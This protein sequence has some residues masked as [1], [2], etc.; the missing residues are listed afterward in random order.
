MKRSYQKWLMK[1]TA[2]FAVVCL[3]AF[4]LQIYYG[5]SF[6]YS[7]K[8]LSGDGLVQ[9][10]NALVYYGEYLRGILKNIF[11]DHT[12]S[13]P[14]Y[15][16]SIGLG[17]DILTT[18]NYYVMGD[19]LNLLAVLVPGRY[20]ELLYNGLVIVRLYLAGIA[21]YLYCLYHNYDSDKVLPGVLIYVFSFYTIVISVV[22]P[23]FLNPLIYF[24]LILLGIDRVM[25]E[26]KPLLFIFSCVLAAVSNFYFFYMM[27]IL[28][29]IYGIIRYIQYHF[30]EMKCLLLLGE[31]GRFM[32]YY[33]IAIMIA[34]PVF[35]PSAFAV[36]G[37]SRV[38]GRSYIP[39]LYEWI[40]Y[41]KLPIAFMNA[42]ADHYSALGYGAVGA[43]AVI[44]LFFRTK[45][46]E[47]AG[48]KVAFLTGT[49]FLLFPFF[50]HVFNGFGYAVN[51]WVWGYCFVV[52]LIVVEMFH[53]II[54]LPPVFEWI[55][56]GLTIVFMI[57]T[58]LF[59]ADDRS[60]FLA[61][62]IV[63]SLFSL[64]LAAVVL[65]C[66][67]L[68]K[69][70][71][72]VYITMIVANI[73]LSMFSFYSP[74]SG[75]DMDQHGNAGSAYSDIMSGPFSVLE[76]LNKEQFEN[77]R[78]DTSNLYFSGVRANSAM[79]YDV[80]SIS[81]YYS[82]INENTNTFFHE[83]WLPTPYENSYV[84][85]DSRAM[86]AALM[87]VK[88]N[89]IR[90]GDEKYLPYGYYHLSAEKKGYALYETEYWLP[91][92]FI[93]DSAMSEE[94]YHTL[95]A[96]QKQQALLQ[97]AVVSET[98][99]ED[100]NCNITEITSGELQF[101]DTISDYVIEEM[102]GIET[103]ENGIEVMEAGA[104]MVLKTNSVSNAE[105][106]LA[107]ENLRYEGDVRAYI[108]VS[109][110][111]VKKKFEI[112]SDL[113]G[114]YANVHDFLCNLGYSESHGESC[115][116]IFGNPGTYTFSSIKII[117]QPLENMEEQVRARKE[118][119]V[120]YFLG[121][122]SISIHVDAQKDGLLYLS[123]PFSKGWEACVDGKK[124]KVI[125][126]NDFGM[127]FFITPGKHTVE[128]VYHTPYMRLGGI[129][130]IFGLAG[131]IA[132]LLYDRIK[133]KVTNLF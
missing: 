16:L 15:D 84:D 18:L 127:G 132:I 29:V 21:F 116:I 50:G 37:S 25:R 64:I 128:L 123:V 73:F 74:L 96:I 72:A 48:W 24:P 7:A 57:P 60:K 78:I 33:V 14:E 87:G 95:S 94:E 66:R 93:Y 56:A 67:G 88:Y 113:D 99:L 126:T 62:V 114:A 104:F 86:L 75:D 69:G 2:T 101:C 81:F 54:A 90:P 83:S 71:Q 22:H 4:S 13:I 30:K 32:G 124:T 107:F 58:F 77:V 44:L 27:T 40:Y 98:A 6:V 42:S 105:R 125:K 97:T 51:R 43:L 17:G 61:A 100:Q 5:K 26:R 82:V 121:E 129:L 103:S 79:L 109:D 110:G 106:C 117:N 46:K 133:W 59:R 111:N 80:N 131:C 23:F 47:K 41:I 85:L 112:K 20:M 39:F 38:G 49:I 55:T 122:D 35:L 120:D 130:M 115:Q 12:F 108:T 102:S 68:K 1:Y 92:T 28:M 119:E 36:F 89:I 10:Y 9:H 11:V 19:P 31:L 53:E 91:M 34:A 65:L 52:S 70:T 8:S 3:I 76:G 63:L 118:S 45:W